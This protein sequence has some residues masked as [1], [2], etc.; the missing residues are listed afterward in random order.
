MSAIQSHIM[1]NY[2]QV[3]KPEGDKLES[4]SR[5]ESAEARAEK[6][7]N[8]FL[9]LLITQIQN[10][11]PTDPM[12]NKELSQLTAAYS[13]VEQQIDSNKHLEKL[14]NASQNAAFGTPISYLGTEITTD[15][16]VAKLENGKAVF[17][18]NLPSECKEAQITVLNE[19]GKPVFVA[20]GGTDTGYNEFT[21]DG[22]DEHG[23]LHPN[24]TYKINV[25]AIGSDK[26]RLQQV[27]NAIKLNNGEGKIS[28]KIPEDY[29]NASITIKNKDNKVILETIG[30]KNAGTH[31][32]NWNGMD[33]ERKTVDDGEYNIEIRANKLNKDSIP[34]E[35][36]EFS[37][38][39]EKISLPYN[40]NEDYRDAII[41]VKNEGG[42]EVYRTKG[43]NFAGQHKFE[44]DG[45]NEK[46][47]SLPLDSKY[48]LEITG[49]K[50]NST[51]NLSIKADTIMKG[52]VSGIDGSSN[53]PSVIVNGK[54]IA[55]N[56]IKS[57]SLPNSNK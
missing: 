48:K 23:V 36:P 57:V 35:N 34:V 6:E 53:T 16:S 17:S 14:V 33:S 43:E 15:S 45:K 51:K 9:K 46:G 37:L 1:N 27:N 8:Q 3:K 25:D 55:L 30:E 44:W 4:G 21:W 52:I 49:F 20:K 26:E 32:F 13:Q 29:H 54:Q 5:A 38:T 11:I 47:N 56:T 7:K 10:Q 2:S 40:L 50:N 42:V 28:Y 41:S 39:G 12:E 24:G 22:K 18:Y 31:E 19:K